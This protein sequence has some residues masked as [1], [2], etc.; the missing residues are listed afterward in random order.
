MALLVDR[1]ALKRSVA[2][3]RGQRPLEWYT[4]HGLTVGER[5]KLIAPFDLDGSH[6]W[7][8]SI[9]DDVTFAPGVRILAHDA[10]TLLT[11]GYTRI[12]RV[13]VGNRVFVGAD[14]T[15]LP[16]T[17]MGDDVVI[18]AGSVVSSDVPDGTIAVGA[19]ARPI[20]LAAAYRDKIRA[21]FAERPH[22]DASWTKAAGITRAQKEEMRSLLSDG[23]G[24]VV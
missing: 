24:Y 9:G 21:E 18:G 22:F 20:G 17:T 14:S 3:V 7:L 6:C 23:A 5:P 13:T 15:I 4:R 19:P 12:A 10:S 1:R 8:I 11:V 16:G 2:R